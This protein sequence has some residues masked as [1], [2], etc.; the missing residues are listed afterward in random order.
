MNYLPDFHYKTTDNYGNIV[1]IAPCDSVFSDNHDIILS[2]D[3][4]HYKC[5]SC[6]QTSA[7]PI[8]KERCRW[9]LESKNSGFGRKDS[10]KEVKI[11][12][13]DLLELPT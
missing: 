7:E 3:R 2:S 1:F 13:Y 6:G 12:K 9:H 8:F 11:G 5:S 4:T 10:I